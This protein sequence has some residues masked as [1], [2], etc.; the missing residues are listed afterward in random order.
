MPP[1]LPKNGEKRFWGIQV[2]I[3]GILGA[4][5]SAI[6]TVAGL[7]VRFG[8][9]SSLNCPLVTQYLCRNAILWLVWSVLISSGG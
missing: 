7:G 1:V 4:V 2:R 3:S 5:L 9:R 8:M 6:V